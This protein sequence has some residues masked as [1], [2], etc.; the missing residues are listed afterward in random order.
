M[1]KISQLAALAS[2]VAGARAATFSNS[3]T[4][5]ISDVSVTSVDTGSS[6]FQGVQHAA[7]IEISLKASQPGEAWITVPEDVFENFPDSPFQWEYGTVTSTGY[8]NNNFSIVFDKVP[9]NGEAKLGIF[10]KMDY[11]Y[12]AAIT[13]PTKDT[14]TF[15]SSSGEFKSSVAYNQYPTDQV[16]VHTENSGQT[17][18]WDVYVPASLVN[19]T[20]TISVEKQA[21]YKFSPEFNNFYYNMLTTAFDQYGSDE[22]LAST[23]QIDVS[24]EDKINV[25]FVGALPS[26]AVGLRLNFHATI[27]ESREFFTSVS[28]VQFSSFSESVTAY[29]YTKN[30]HGFV[31]API[32]KINSAS[33]A[34][35]T[36]AVVQSS[37]TAATNGTSATTGST[38]ATG[39]ASVTGS[40]PASISASASKSGSVSASGSANGTFAST[41]ATIA[42]GS[43]SVPG[44]ASVSGSASGFASA[45]GYAAASFGVNCT[46]GCVTGPVSTAT[47]TAHSLSTTV[48]T[49][50]PTCEVKATTVAVSTATTTEHGVVT[51]YTTYCP[52]SA[53]T[54]SY[55]VS[56]GT[57]LAPSVVITEVQSGV[58][59]VYTTY[60]PY[61]ETASST[62]TRTVATS[63]ASEAPVSGST[64]EGVTTTTKG[65]HSGSAPS[66]TTVATVSG[67]QAPKASASSS[68]TVSTYEGAAVAIKGGFSAIILGFVAFLI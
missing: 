47:A 39:S 58:F 40:A 25:T 65:A 33:S 1:V 12:T 68:I 59:T 28:D 7:F 9:K 38:T 34:V 56:K 37:T 29:T 32:L 5:V 35:T 10:T 66:A 13:A 48:I 41:G 3:T 19:S 45:S 55:T 62:S 11:G 50:C 61:S 24:T 46:S 16:Y 17:L 15:T 18:E 31:E 36:G 8:N 23:E 63:N 27:E 26:T 43:A 67:S 44:S 30:Y 64:A 52:I 57:T 2:A 42:T 53:E 51:A 4:P 14:F 54:G 22:I 49:T 20:F 21:G 60:C 6:E